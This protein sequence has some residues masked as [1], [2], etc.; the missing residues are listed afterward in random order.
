MSLGDFSASRTE[1]GV[2]KQYEL[3]SDEITKVQLR[4]IYKY[5]VR[6]IAVWVGKSILMCEKPHLTLQAWPRLAPEIL[7]ILVYSGGTCSSPDEGFTPRASKDSWQQ[8]VATRYIQ[9]IDLYISDH[10][11][12]QNGEFR[13][14]A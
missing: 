5:C 9:A 3:A 8:P 4:E 10:R 1:D 6:D 11:Y 2:N 13:A 14:R 12:R 7:F